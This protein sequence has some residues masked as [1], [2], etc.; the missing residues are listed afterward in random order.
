MME[1]RHRHTGAAILSLDGDT[2]AGRDLC[3]L[4]LREADLRGA[5][6]R[7]ARLNETAFADCG[8]LAEAMGLGAVV[9][10]GPSTLDVRTLRAALPGAFLMG[11]GYTAEEI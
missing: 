5:D 8:T 1:I 11:A 2:L 7:G 4:S 3:G 10:D 9:H 6:L